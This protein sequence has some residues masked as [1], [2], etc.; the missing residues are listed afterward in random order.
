MLGLFDYTVFD[1]FTRAWGI[2]GLAGSTVT[3]RRPG[4]T[5]KSISSIGTAPSNTSS[6]STNAPT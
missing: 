5:T 4:D 3:S 6:P 2:F 1:R